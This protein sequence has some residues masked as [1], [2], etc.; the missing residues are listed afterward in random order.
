MESAYFVR[1]FCLC[2]FGVLILVCLFSPHFISEGDTASLS[3]IELEG[4]GS[5]VSLLDK[6]SLKIPS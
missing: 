3:S 2:S 4:G 6:V 1:D 5:H